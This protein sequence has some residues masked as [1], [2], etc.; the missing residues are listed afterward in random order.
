MRR[1]LFL[2][3]IALFLTGDHQPVSAR[4]ILSEPNSWKS[5]LG[6]DAYIT[7]GPC[8]T[9]DATSH[10]SGAWN[11]CAVDLRAGLGTPILAPAEGGVSK[12][13]FDGSGGG[14]YLVLEHGGRASLYIHLSGYAVSA[15]DRV[16]QGD[17]IAYSGKGGTGPHLHFTAME[18]TSL[19]SCISMVGIDSNTN[20]AYGQTFR[21]TNLPAGVL[22][23]SPPPT[24]PPAPPVPPPSGSPPAAP[25]LVTPGGSQ[26]LPPSAEITF[27]WG[28]VSNATQYYIEYWGD[29]YGTL[30]SGWQFGASFRLG[31]MWPGNYSWRVKARN[32]AGEGDWSE[33]RDFIIAEST[34]TPVPTNTPQP[35]APAAPSLREPAGGAS[36]AQTADVWFSWHGAAGATQYYLEY[37]G[38]SYGTLNS[39]WIGDTA[40]RIGTMWPGDYSW[41]VKA[42][43]YNGLESNWSETWTFTIQESASPTSPPA[44]ATSPTDT[45]VPPPPPPTDTPVP[46]TQPPIQGNIGPQSGRSPNGGGSNNAFDGDLS[47][48]WVDGLGH[49][50]T[51]TLSLPGTVTINRIIVWDRPQN[52]PDNNQI[53]ALVIALGNGVSKRFDMISQGP[54]CIDVTLSS[55]QA[56]SSVTLR[57]DDGSGNNGLSEVE[58]WAGP[59]TGG[60]SCAN[61]G[62]LP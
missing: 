37:W 26:T 49:K 45:P 19:R 30:N 10:C 17:L 1:V 47:T 50:F 57:V 41:R 13:G 62:T 14:N 7:Q 11:L 28:S 16:S 40:Y 36:L 12:T 44:T 58:I 56:V 34:A 43:D 29:P 60:P 6:Y 20:L 33:T 61:T 9:Q 3:I 2:L 53:N 18:N 4:Q 54:R 31:T 59:K 35:Q 38:G 42:R 52:S 32:S 25:A 22:P 48:F 24:I 46:P 8:G 5:P 39:G 27:E 55:P 15:G 23:P 21:S 51:L